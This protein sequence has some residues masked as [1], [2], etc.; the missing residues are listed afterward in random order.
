MQ[1][2]KRV[3]YILTENTRNAEN[4]HFIGAKSNAPFINLFIYLNGFHAVHLRFI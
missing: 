3:L 2:G 4:A 1:S